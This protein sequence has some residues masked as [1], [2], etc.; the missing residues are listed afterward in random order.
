M[1]KSH[2]YRTGLYGEIV[3]HL[4]AH[5]EQHVWDSVGYMGTVIM[6][7]GGVLSGHTKIISLGGGTDVAEGSTISLCVYGDLE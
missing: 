6:Q 1:W 5:G 2:S 7:H 3:S 4:P